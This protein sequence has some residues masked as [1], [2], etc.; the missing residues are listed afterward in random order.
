[1]HENIIRLKAVA[2]ALKGLGQEYVFVG[3]ATVSLYAT[4]PE[5]ATEVRPTDDVDVVVEL[6]SYGGYAELDEKLRGMGFTNDIE[7]GVICRYTIQGIIVD[8]M[9]TEPKVIGFSNKWYPEGFQS[10]VEHRLDDEV[11]IRRFSLVYFIA[12]KW[13]AFKGR[14]KNDYRTS[15]DFEDLVYVMENVND[16]EE[17]MQEIPEHLKGYLHESFKDVLFTDAFEEGLYAHLT[18]GYRGLDANYI[19]LRLQQA[20]GIA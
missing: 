16:F 9:P 10:A 18:G 14:G 12:T 7:S 8:V 13:E 3:G 5:L 20:F 4:D 19:V 11:T 17:Q 2:L 15:K 1:M 6:A